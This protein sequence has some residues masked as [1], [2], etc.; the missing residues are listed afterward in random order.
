[1]YR[2]WI[3][4]IEI[5]SEHHDGHYKTIE[6]RHRISRLIES[7]PVP[8]LEMYRCTVLLEEQVSDEEAAPAP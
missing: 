5:P 4:T 8:A 6:L 1:M 3:A 7:S 2:Y